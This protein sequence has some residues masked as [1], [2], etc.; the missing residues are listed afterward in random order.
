MLSL[1]LPNS[2]NSPT[3]NGKEWSKFVVKESTK[4]TAI[5]IPKNNSGDWLTTTPISK[6]PADPPIPIIFPLDVYFFSIKY[7]AAA[8]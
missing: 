6:P 5:I 7:L 2:S 4:G 3:V 1:A 8:I